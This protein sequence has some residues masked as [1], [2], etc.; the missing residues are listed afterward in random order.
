MTVDLLDL[1]GIHEVL[2]T[3]QVD[4]PRADVV[5]AAQTAVHE[6]IRSEQAVV[7][8]AMRGRRR[9]RMLVG[10]VAAVSAVALVHAVPTLGVNGHRGSSAEA[11]TFLRGVATT[12]AVQSSAPAD[13]AYWYFR[14]TMTS[15]GKTK[16]RQ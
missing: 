13:A 2:A 3:G 15:D 7:F 4:R 8:G 6:A 11:A 5:A 12:A 16:D 10:G 14:S 9:K 1:P